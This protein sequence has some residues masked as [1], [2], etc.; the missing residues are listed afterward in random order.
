M[1]RWWPALALWPTYRPQD[2][3]C[4]PL[5]PA[6]LAAPQPSAPLGMDEMPLAAP[7][8]EASAPMVLQMGA[9][10]ELA[11]AEAIAYLVSMSLLFAG[12]GIFVQVSRPFGIGLPRVR[13]EIII[14]DRTASAH[15]PAQNIR[16]ADSRGLKQK[17]PRKSA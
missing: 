11:P 4:L 14:S 16:A 5:P 3:R 13:S 7:A 1:L 9:G 10:G 15:S 2:Q 17:N 6:P 12:L 8:A